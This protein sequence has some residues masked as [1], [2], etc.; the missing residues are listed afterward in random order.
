[1]RISLVV[2]ALT[3]VHCLCSHNLKWRCFGAGHRRTSFIS[4]ATVR[5][6][7]GATGGAR[8]RHQRRRA[9]FLERA[10]WTLD[11]GISKTGFSV[12][13]VNAQRV[14]VGLTLTVNAEMKV[15]SEPLSSK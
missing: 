9:L 13:Q 5:L 12:Y 6:T 15:G 14:E 3:V 2:W 7:D 8:H 11:S 4:G 1:M 10:A